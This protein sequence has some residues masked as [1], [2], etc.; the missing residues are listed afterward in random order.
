[1]AGIGTIGF[2]ADILGIVSFFESN[3]EGAGTGGAVVKIGTALGDGPDTTV[4]SIR[5]NNA[6]ILLQ[7]LTMHRAE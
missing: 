3:F 7:A 5:I 4:V 6:E 1:M 2:V